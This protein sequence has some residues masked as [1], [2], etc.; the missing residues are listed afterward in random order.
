[1]YQRVHVSQNYGIREED[2]DEAVSVTA[3]DRQEMEDPDNDEPMRIIGELADVMSLDLINELLDAEIIE[4][5][6][7]L[8]QFMKVKNETS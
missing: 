1:M 6:I 2:A 5:L 4:A 8:K 3:A 7:M